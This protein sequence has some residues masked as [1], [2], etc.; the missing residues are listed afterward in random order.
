MEITL[1]EFL[2][3]QPGYPDEAPTDK[4]YLEIANSLS[5][6]WDNSNLL[7]DVPEETK[8]S[9]VLGITGY[10]QDIIADAGIWRSFCTLN[11]ELYGTPLPVIGIDSG[12]IESELNEIDIQ[13]LIWYI[14]ECNSDEYGQLSPSCQELKTLAGRFYNIL[15]KHYESAPVPVEYNLITD[16]DLSDYE[17]MQGIFDLSYW[18]FWNSYLMRHAATPAFRQA[19]AEARDIINANPDPEAARPLLADLNQR[20]MIENPTGPLA[21]FINEWLRL[22]IDN[23]APK[24]LAV[25]KAEAPHKFYVNFKKASYGEDLVFCSNYDELNNFLS[26]NMDWGNNPD[27]HLP[28]LKAFGNFVLYATPE[29][30]LLVAHDISQFIKHPQNKLYNRDAAASQAYTMIT[31]QGICPIDLTKYLFSNNLVPD[32]VLPFD[33][34]GGKI[35]LDNWDFLARLYLQSFYRAV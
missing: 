29:K 2:T 23:K 3:M 11:K 4:Y 26:K 5:K 17:N 20:I 21:L 27:G 7:P 35:L 32:A 15:D 14:I 24:E 10:F 22:I 34:T 1:K 8:H 12:Y 33:K 30:G 9:V 25:N 28:G 19:M 16:V 13:F 31:G 18:L 6:E